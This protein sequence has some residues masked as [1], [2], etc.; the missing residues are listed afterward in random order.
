[1]P[2]INLFPNSFWFDIADWTQTTVCNTDRD[3]HGPGFAGQCSKVDGGTY[4]KSGREYLG[5]CTPSECGIYS[6]C[7]DIGDVCNEG[8]ISGE[9]K[10]KGR[11]VYEEVKIIADCEISLTRGNFQSKILARKFK[12]CHF[13][14]R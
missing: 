9:C 2:S 14:S 7:P 5:W 3:C 10:V 1:M 4:D 12:F 13:R 6:G 8:M 11:C